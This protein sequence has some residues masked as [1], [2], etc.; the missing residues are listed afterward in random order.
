[1]DVT[2][3][4]WKK[5]FKKLFWLEF[6]PF[7][8]MFFITLFY[9]MWALLHD[10]DSLAKRQENYIY[11][12]IAGTLDLIFMVFFIYQEYIQLRGEDDFW[13]YFDVW[14][15][16]DIVWMVMGPM[17]IVASIPIEPLLD[18]DHLIVMSAIL[19]FCLSG[20]VIDWMR[21]FDGTAFY[22]Y[23]IYET[24]REIWAFMILI[25]MSL[26]MFGVPMIILNMNR[27]GEE[28]GLIVEDEMGFWIS[29]MFIN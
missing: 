6:I 7:S 5:N 19:M 4:I 29:D 20:K 26:V 28:E 11:R 17:V 1:M 2:D 10:E 8:A 24:L 14:N 3:K 13:D 18:Y 23:L 9:M 12:F 16:L 27:D 15:A 21:L 25:F 22:V